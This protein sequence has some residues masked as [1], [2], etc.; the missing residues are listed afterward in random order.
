MINNLV[1][2]QSNLCMWF[3]TIIVYTAIKKQYQYIIDYRMSKI[4]QNKL[5]NHFGRKESNPDIKM[6]AGRRPLSEPRAENGNYIGNTNRPLNEPQH[7]NEM[8]GKLTKNIRYLEKE[9][10]IFK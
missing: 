9:L 8:I 10:I 3:L 5:I 4:F 2:N 7:V 6:N 1:L